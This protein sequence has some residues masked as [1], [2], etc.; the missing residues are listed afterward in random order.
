MHDDA[1]AF[2][3]ALGMTSDNNKT[4]NNRTTKCS[5]PRSAAQAPHAH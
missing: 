1:S 3:S 5:D 4:T 2:A